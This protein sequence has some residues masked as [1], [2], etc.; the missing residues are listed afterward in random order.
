MMPWQRD[1]G[2]TASNTA[3]DEVAALSTLSKIIS[4]TLVAWDLSANPGSI[5]DEQ[6]AARAYALKCALVSRTLDLAQLAA[7]QRDNT[8]RNVMHVLGKFVD[9]NQLEKIHQLLANGHYFT[10]NALGATVQPRRALLETGDTVTAMSAVYAKQ[11]RDKRANVL[12]RQLRGTLARLVNKLTLAGRRKLTARVQQFVDHWIGVC[13]K[14]ESEGEGASA[15]ENTRRVCVLFYIGVHKLDAKAGRSPCAQVADTR[16]RNLV[17]VINV[18]REVGVEDGAEHV[19]CVAKVS[20]GGGGYAACD[21]CAQDPEGHGCSNS[22]GL[23]GSNSNH[24]NNNSGEATARTSTTSFCPSTPQDNFEDESDRALFEMALGCY[25]EQLVVAGEHGELKALGLSTRVG[26]YEGV[27]QVSTRTLAIVA[28]ST[29][30]P[31]LSTIIEQFYLAIAAPASAQ[32]GRCGTDP[33]HDAFSVPNLSIQVELELVMRTRTFEHR[34][35]PP[36][37]RESTSQQQ[38]GTLCKEKRDKVELATREKHATF[39]RKLS[40]KRIDVAVEDAT[41]GVGHDGTVSLVVLSGDPSLQAQRRA[42]R[43]Y[44]SRGPS[45]VLNALAMFLGV[46]PDQVSWLDT[47]PVFNQKVPKTT[48]QGA[49]TRRNMVHATAK[50]VSALA[51]RIVVTASSIAAQ[52]TFAN[53]ANISGGAPSSVVGH[54]GAVG[55][56]NASRHL[57]YSTLVFTIS[58]P[59]IQQDAVVVTLMDGG[60]AKHIDHDNVILSCALVVPSA[61]AWILTRLLDVL[62]HDVE[63]NK[64]LEEYEAVINQTILCKDGSTTTL[65]D[66]FE[67]IRIAAAKRQ[68]DR[69][70][71][72]TVAVQEKD[73][74]SDADDDDVDDDCSSGDDVDGEDDDSDFLALAKREHAVQ[75]SRLAGA[76]RSLGV[77][78][79]K[80]H[81][82]QIVEALLRMR[83]RAVQKLNPENKL[84]FWLNVYRYVWRA[85]GLGDSGMKVMHCVVNAQVGFVKRSSNPTNWEVDFAYISKAPKSSYVWNGI[86]DSNN[87]NKVDSNNNMLLEEDGAASWFTSIVEK[88]VNMQKQC[89]EAPTQR[90]DG[91]PHMLCHPYAVDGQLR[92]S[93]H[94]NGVLSMANPPHARR[95]ANSLL[96]HIGVRDQ[97]NNCMLPPETPRRG[98]QSRDGDG[99]ALVLVGF[100]GKENGQCDSLTYLSVLRTLEGELLPPRDGEKLRHEGTKVVMCGCGKEQKYVYCE[101]VE[102][103][104]EVVPAPAKHLVVCLA[105]QLH[106]NRLKWPHMSQR[107]NV[108]SLF[109]IRFV[110]SVVVKKS[111]GRVSSTGNGITALT[112]TI[113]AVRELFFNPINTAEYVMKTCTDPECPRD[114]VLVDVNKR[115]WTKVCDSTNPK[116]RP[117]GAHVCTSSTTLPTVVDVEQHQAAQ[118]GRDVPPTR[119]SFQKIAG[120]N[121]NPE[122]AKALLRALDTHTCH[123]MG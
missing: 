113:K 88:Q 12:L 120:R 46:S 14:F 7:Q 73:R 87:H 10:S 82:D 111:P 86:I 5:Q 21:T 106:M 96:R 8:S 83:P 93:G 91:G 55:A 105:L 47:L 121:A 33:M 39:A 51:P 28:D 17:V 123:C 107:F 65:I 44:H 37:P 102:Y 116:H 62:G 42:T 9:L 48:A 58:Q 30:S 117:G 100:C 63:T 27:V 40:E 45:I 6:Q 3:V 11:P 115:G 18:G 53:M 114:G 122:E 43:A 90:N 56:A 71:T 24:S 101:D 16:G 64:L 34:A 76:V 60:Y 118:T 78:D 84:R 41:A 99:A 54:E 25:Y 1:G 98:Q 4:N 112:Q 95:K 66:T 97:V 36:G 80:V 26:W 110:G 94:F 108:G 22:G 15:N 119:L 85:I 20:Y 50:E 31:R 61:I 29:K 67:S 70:N 104:R 77:L 35:Q 2:A 13:D 81:P 74:G 89:L 38:D 19:T 75:Y 109:A 59:G 52:A 72:T 57:S 23:G 32:R 68:F 49:M 103:M 69:N 92:L 79:T